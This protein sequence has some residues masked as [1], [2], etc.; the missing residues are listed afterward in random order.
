MAPGFVQTMYL[1][2]CCAEVHIAKIFELISLAIFEKQLILRLQTFYIAL[3]WSCLQK[4]VSKFAKSV[5]KKYI[6]RPVI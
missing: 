1:L 2:P 3:K 6:P 4:R 5:F